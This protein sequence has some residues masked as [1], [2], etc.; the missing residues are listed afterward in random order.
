MD[1]WRAGPNRKNTTKQDKE[2]TAKKKRAKN[3]T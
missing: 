1:L 2:K 3:K